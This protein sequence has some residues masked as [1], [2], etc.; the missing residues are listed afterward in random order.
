MQN[1]Q[2]L[3]AG[4][5]YQQAALQNQANQANFNAS[6]GYTGYNPM[7]SPMNAGIGINAGFNFGFR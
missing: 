2:S 3:Q 1:Q 4:N 7:Y 6:G 5:Y